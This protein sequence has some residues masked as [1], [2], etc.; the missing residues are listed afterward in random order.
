M[1]DALA[2]IEVAMK[3]ISSSSGGDENTIDANYHKLKCGM[4]PVEV[5]SDCCSLLVL[6]VSFLLAYLVLKCAER[7][8][9]VE[10]CAAICQEHARLHAH[11]LLSGY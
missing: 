1:C 7:K 2:D 8:R 4:T 5:S 6:L 10:D 3:L 11:H 9:G